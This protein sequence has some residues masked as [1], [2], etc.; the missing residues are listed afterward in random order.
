MNVPAEIYK[1]IL[2]HL[3]WIVVTCHV[4]SVT[5]ALLVGMETDKQV[6][7]TSMLEGNMKPYKQDEFDRRNEPGS[8]KNHVRTFLFVQAYA[9]NLFPLT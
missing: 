2:T 4:S 9:L 7:F 1:M 6:M 3:C 8:V 5:L